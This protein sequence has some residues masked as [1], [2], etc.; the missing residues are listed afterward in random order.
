ML[1]IHGARTAL[2]GLAKKDT[3]L[4]RWV[5]AL[6][7]RAHRNV[8]TVA[9][10]NKLARIAWTVLAGDRWYVWLFKLRPIVA[11][12]ARPRSIEDPTTAAKGR[13]EMASQSIGA[14]KA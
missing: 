10:A 12:E 13:N 8:V 1:L 2:P 9:L 11:A 4:G 5:K 6:L 3:P 14:L 7:A